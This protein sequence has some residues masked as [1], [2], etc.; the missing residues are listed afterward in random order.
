M[1]D[2]QTQPYADLASQ[3]VET[4]KYPSEYRDLIVLTLTDSTHWM[5]ELDKRDY[6]PRTVLFNPIC[7]RVTYT[8]NPFFLSVYW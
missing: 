4:N 7:T 2:I 3:I 5:Y 6:S 1:I 8:K